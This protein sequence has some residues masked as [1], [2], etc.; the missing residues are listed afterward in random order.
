MTD[1]V[2]ENGFTAQEKELI[3]LRNR[4]RD[5]E[6][7]IERRKTVLD[8]KNAL[9]KDLRVNTG[10]SFAEFR[11]VNVERAKSF[12]SAEQKW[13]PA[14]WMVALMGEVGELAAV[15][16]ETGVLANEAEMMKRCIAALGQ[17]ANTMK[18]LRRGVDYTKGKS[19]EELKDGLHREFAGFVWWSRRLSDVLFNIGG[20]LTDPLPAVRTEVLEDGDPAGEVGDVQT[21]LDL[22]AHSVG[23]DLGPATVA[24]FNE[25]SKRVGSP[26]VLE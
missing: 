26:L 9:L 14:D 8:F 22:L 12:P 5:L 4:V 13:T 10:L 11:A 24:K 17:V 16:P 6:A 19:Q 20:K 25:V 21:Y 18:K 7:E 23:V 3:A 2:E 1:D 15:L